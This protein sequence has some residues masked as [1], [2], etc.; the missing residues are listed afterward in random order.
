MVE[1]V[2][3]FEGG[4]RARVAG[5]VSRVAT[6][7]PLASHEHEHALALAVREPRYLNDDSAPAARSD[8]SNARLYL[9]F[10]CVGSMR[11]ASWK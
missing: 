6:R 2:F 10:S 8:S 3:V 9:A 5:R 11:R 1:G 4:S 7:K